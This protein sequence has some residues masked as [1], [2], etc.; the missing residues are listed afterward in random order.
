MGYKGWENYDP[1][2]PC[3]N[4]KRQLQ[5]KINRDIGDAFEQYIIAACEAYKLQKLAR[6]E[7]TPEPF[8]VIGSKK[9]NEYGIWVFEGYFT[10][11]AQPDFQGTLRGGRSIV[12]EAKTS[13]TDRID[14][15]D[16]TANQEDA[17]EWHSS[18][19]ALAYV[20]VSIGLKAFYR[21]PWETWRDMKQIYGRK[22]L[23]L[24]DL[25]PFRLKEHN[26]VILLFCGLI[27]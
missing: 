13:Q 17:L 24:A 22:H 21:V 7:K 10:A 8:K 2:A 14:R 5:G 23:K 18:L 27:A 26:G 3:K 4:P 15:S 12:F 20:Y 19:G 9:Q 6:V 16:V 25:E 1:S 11:P